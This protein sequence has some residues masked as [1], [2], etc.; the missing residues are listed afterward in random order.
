[1]DFESKY[2]NFD[3]NKMD[4]EMSSAKSLPFYLSDN[5]LET[6]C[7]FIKP[8][9]LHWYTVGIFSCVKYILW[10]FHTEM[11]GITVIHWSG[12]II[13]RSASLSLA[14]LDIFNVSIH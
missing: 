5:G 7:T 12:V 11:F 3:S 13:V 9:I 2:E 8:H 1:M 10:Y 6:T 4:L 14:A